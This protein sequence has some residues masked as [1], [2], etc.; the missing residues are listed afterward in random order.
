MAHPFELSA[1]AAAGVGSDYVWADHPARE[2]WERVAE[3]AVLTWIDSIRMVDIERVAD[4]CHEVTDLGVKVR[5]YA[6]A[7]IAELRTIAAEG[8]K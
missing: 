4:A 3:R 5:D 2:Y 1:R 8:K 6:V 7:S